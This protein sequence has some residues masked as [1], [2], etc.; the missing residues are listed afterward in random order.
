MSTGSRG[1][2][3]LPTVVVKTHTW[4]P[5]EYRLRGVTLYYLSQAAKHQTLRNTIPHT[6]G[7]N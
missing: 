4:G 5:N 2:P 7:P 3:V 6:L 1:E